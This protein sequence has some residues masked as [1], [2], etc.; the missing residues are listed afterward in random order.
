MAPSRRSYTS[1]GPRFALEIANDA[2][3]RVRA[4]NKKALDPEAFLKVTAR[5]PKPHDSR[6]PPPGAWLERNYRGQRIA[7]KGPD[8][9]VRVRGPR[10]QDTDHRGEPGNR[11]TLEWFCL[12][13]VARPGRGK[14]CPG[15]ARSTGAWR[16]P[17]SRSNCPS[18]R[19]CGARSTRASRPRKAFSRS[20]IRSMRSEPS[21]PGLKHFFCSCSIRIESFLGCFPP[22]LYRLKSGT[23]PRKLATP[24]STCTTT[25]DFS[26]ASRFCTGTAM[27]IQVG[28]GFSIGC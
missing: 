28:C 15:I 27:T 20:S 4:P 22:T 17:R 12:L 16:T 23:V 14:S 7:I 24:Q 10:V 2:D 13:W 3:I 19:R 25:A 6:L 9:W 11:R 1:P 8:R 5:L 26:A 18:S 21:L